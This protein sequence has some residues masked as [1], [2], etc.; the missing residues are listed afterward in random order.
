VLTF[1]IC[2]LALCTGLAT[3]AKGGKMDSGVKLDK[4]MFAA[5]CFWKVQYIFSKTPGVAH[6]TVGYS[7]GKT[8]DPNYKQVCTDSTG[9]AE[10]VLVEYDPAKVSYKKLLEVFWTN[11][12][13]TTLNRQGPDVGTQYRSSVFYLN[14]Q[15]KAEAI[16]V[17]AELDKSGKFKRPIVT[18]IVPAGQF[19]KAE[20]YHQNYFEKNGQ[21]CH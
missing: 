1:A 20:D 19:Y 11:H 21:V 2:S 12:D 16:Q 5:G 9:H 18:E 17:K 14:D 8:P 7:G 4:A 6:T 3:Q 15:Q 13:P 10:V